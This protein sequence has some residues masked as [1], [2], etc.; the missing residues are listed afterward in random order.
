MKT[1]IELLKEEIER[2]TEKLSTLEAVGLVS[3]V[4]PA[5]LIM[6]QHAKI[7][8]LS[9]RIE[10]QVENM[11]AMADDI[12]AS[13]LKERDTLKSRLAE[14]EGIAADLFELPNDHRSYCDAVCMFDA[15]CNCGY[16]E[17]LAR[18]TAY[19]DKKG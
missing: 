8:V 6:S 3:G 15:P 4:S 18:Y 10:W 2:L 7:E 19:P 16:T 1:E 14:I 13:T 11:V 12:T 17:I 5:D 9:K